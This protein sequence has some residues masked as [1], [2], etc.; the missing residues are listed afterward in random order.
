MTIS[1]NSVPLHPQVIP[2][3]EYNFN[4]TYNRVC[5]YCEQ[6]L[7]H[8]MHAYNHFRKYHSGHRAWIY[9]RYF[10]WFQDVWVEVTKDV[11]LLAKGRRPTAVAKKGGNA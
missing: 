9:P 10:V 1:V 6:P 2:P 7:R 5:L 3:L 8:E 4:F 11:Y